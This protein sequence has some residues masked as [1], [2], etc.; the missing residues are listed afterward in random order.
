MCNAVI[1]EEDEAAYQAALVRIRERDPLANE[2][3]K[4]HTPGA[5]I[6]SVPGSR[7]VHHVLC[8]KCYDQMQILVRLGRPVLA[9]R[10]CKDMCFECRVLAAADDESE[11]P[12]IG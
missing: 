3:G 7:C 1:P 5:R 9:E 6:H 8:D 10:V 2:C 12:P 4:C 11:T